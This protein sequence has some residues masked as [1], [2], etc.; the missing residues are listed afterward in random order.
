[1]LT[2]VMWSDL[3]FVSFLT[4]VLKTFQDEYIVLINKNEL[5]S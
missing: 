1:M 3:N 2:M 4:F 5:Y